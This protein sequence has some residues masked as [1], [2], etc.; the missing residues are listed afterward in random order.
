M[1]GDRW[2]VAGGRRGYGKCFRLRMKKAISVVGNGLCAFYD[3]QHPQRLGAPGFVGE[4]RLPLKLLAHWEETEHAA[5]V[6]EE[7][8]FCSN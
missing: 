4:E 5:G 7:D 6:D 1:A 2:P 3:P 8:V